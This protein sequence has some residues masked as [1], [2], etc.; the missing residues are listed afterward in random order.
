MLYKRTLQRVSE[1]EI[2][3]R[4]IT[5]E[6]GT[7]PWKYMVV[8]YTSKAQTPPPESPSFGAGPEINRYGFN[9]TGDALTCAKQMLADSLANG[10]VEL[11]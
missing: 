10:Y 6:D 3:D 2:S 4:T 5:I 8:V 11:P 9:E 1:S 7:P